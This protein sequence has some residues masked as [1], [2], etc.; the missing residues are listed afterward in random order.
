MTRVALLGAGNIGHALAALLGSRAEL[1]V[2]LWSPSVVRARPL[3]IALLHRAG[4]HTVG[5]VR[6]EPSLEAATEGASVVITTVPTHARAGVLRQAAARLHGAALVLAWEGSGWLERELRDCGIE[7]PVVAGFQRSPF[8]ARVRER[9][10]TVDFL[11]ARD[12]SVAACVDAARKPA[13]A[14]LLGGLLPFAVTMAPDFRYAALSP[15]NPLIHPA[16]VFTADL[17]AL[18][19]RAAPSFYGGW[20]DAASAVLLQLHREVRAVREA[21]GL[22]ARYLRTLADRRPRPSAQAVTR[23]LRAMRAL[24]VIPLPLVRTGGACAL[25]TAHRFLREDIDHGLRRIA[26]LGAQA[27]VPM[28]AAGRILHWRDAQCAASAG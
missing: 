12:R 9:W 17:G 23:E 11:G 1:E 6:A 4:V 18:R 5:M 22:S 2:T 7:R 21:L 24:G 8:F 26:A 20:D 13:A 14:R 19:G 25:D 28:P 27:G 10:K 16:R 15:S 3:R